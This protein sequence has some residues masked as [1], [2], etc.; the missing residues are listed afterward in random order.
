MLRCYALSFEEAELSRSPFCE[1]L[2]SRRLLA[3]VT[4]S[5]T[6][7]KLID[8]DTNQPI[9]TIGNG[10]TIDL[11]KLATKHLNVQAI[12]SGGVGSVKFGYD[13]NVSYHLENT[14]PFALAGDNNGDFNAWTPST[15][16]HTLRATPFSLTKAAGVQGTTR[17]VSFTVINGSST[18]SPAAPKN[19]AATLIGASGI[20]LTWSA[21][22]NGSPVSKY[23][24]DYFAGTNTPMQSVRVAGS[25]TSV[26][27]SG[28][29]SF[30]VYSIYVIA[31]DA[32][33][34]RASSHVT[35]MTAATATSKRYL[36]LLDLPK[37]VTG[38]TNEKPQLEVFDINNGHK[39]VKNIPLP[40]GIYGSRGIAANATTQ[41]LYLTFYNT[42]ADTY[43]TGGLLCLDLKTDKVLWKRKY[44][45]SVIPSPDRFDIT[46][47]GKKIYM[48]VGE[49]G[50][51]N[52]WE[53]LDATNGD[54]LGR[55][56]FVTAPHNTIVSTDGTRAFFEGQEKG[57]Q[58]PELKHTIGVVDTA[59]DKVI[60]RVGPFRDVVRPFTINGKASLI[61]ATVNNWVGF[62]VGDVA[63]GKILYT[64]KPPG[65]V[66][67][68]PLPGGAL[69]HGIALTPDEKYLYVVDDLKIGIHVWDVSKIATQAPTY[70]GFIKT[71]ATGKNLAGQKDPNAS[72]DATGVPAWI[73]F[74]R[75]GKYAYPESGE[76][77]DVA[78]RKVIGQLRAKATDPLGNLI[79][80]PY[81]H[82]RFVLEI[83]FD[84]GNVSH[85]ADQFGVGRVR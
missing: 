81:S 18:S 25:A 5:V 38:F 12:V 56:T 46:P 53:V 84:G 23:I 27:L 34:K 4:P 71:R 59:T 3:G 24:I 2:E 28:L 31:V 69:S 63:S 44:D 67:P 49:N 35:S 1:A 20:K 32:A 73:T 72:N 68:N 79:D 37:N 78:T 30:E 80:A 22:T 54:P 57:T 26:N 74:S 82:S 14:A 48:P 45:Q 13:A 42:P 75:D 85:V 65:Y 43:Q 60:Q 62:Q 58:P 10:A 61:F 29:S 55:I 11:S 19:V 8:A 6:A 16:A 52:F 76:I 15:G 77:I 39:W 9:Q 51:D 7:L 83:D 47:D 50:P 70:V 21:P 33:G 41:R 66:L 17:K 40:S 64:V 36:Y